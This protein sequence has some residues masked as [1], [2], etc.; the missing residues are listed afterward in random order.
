[1]TTT[2]E[3]V[4]ANERHFP[5]AEVEAAFARYRAIVEGAHGSDAKDYSAYSSI[6]TEELL[7]IE[8]CMGNPDG[9]PASPL[10]AT[11]HAE[12]DAW[13]AYMMTRDLPPMT[14]PLEWSMIDGNRVA[15]KA[16]NRLPDPPDGS[17]PYEIASMTVMEYAG[18]G[19]F[20]SKEDIYNAK[21]WDDILNRWMAAMGH[22]GRVADLGFGRVWA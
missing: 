7:Y 17:G 18:D 4:R 21:L 10:L 15:F 2:I 3:D 14:F 5:R 12:I 8:H 1:M 6:F 19:K 20:R 13:M 9:R 16:I 22:T 11:T